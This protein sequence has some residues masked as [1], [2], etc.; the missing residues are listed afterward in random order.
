M[1]RLIWALLITLA[2]LLSPVQGELRWRKTW[3]GSLGWCWRIAWL[4]MGLRRGRGLGSWNWH[5]LQILVAGMLRYGRL[6]HW[7]CYTE[8]GFRD[9]ALTGQWLGLVSGLPPEL[10]RCFHLT[11]SRCGWQSRGRLRGSMPVVGVLLLGLRLVLA[12][13][14]I[15]P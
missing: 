15:K 12:K 6:Q 2:I 4:G 9:P 5:S 14:G 13:K 11:F 7:Q 3:S 1:S 10:G 8:I